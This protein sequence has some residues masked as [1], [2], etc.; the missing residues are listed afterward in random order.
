MAMTKL[1]GEM[2]KNLKGKHKLVYEQ[3]AERVRTVPIP[4]L[5][6]KTFEGI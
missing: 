1:A 5:S 2:W 3:V 4:H 6:Y